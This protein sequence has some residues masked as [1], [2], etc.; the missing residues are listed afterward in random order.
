M[1]RVL[2]G[3]LRGVLLLGALLLTRGD[4]RAADD[5]AVADLSKLTQA[6]DDVVM[7]SAKRPQPLREAAASTSV[8]T[9]ADLQA[10]GWKDF[11]EAIR[12]L[13]GFYT[14]HPGDYTY[15]G[16]RGVSL[17]GD[18]NG[19]VLI[20]VDGHLQQEW[21]SH[22][23]YPEQMGLD[24]TMIDH[25]EVLR[26][27]A[28]ALYGSLGFQAIINVVTRRGSDSNWGS[29]TFQLE[30]YTGY[31]AVVNVGHRF[32]N[33]LEFGVSATARY[34]I[35]QSFTYPELT[36]NQL[37]IPSIPR[38]CTNGKTNRDTDRATNGAVYAHLNFRGLTVKA[39]YQ[40]FD[41]KIPMAPYQ[42][43]FNDPTN[44]YV[45]QR[46]Y[47]D[48]GYD[49]GT[50]QTV[51]ATVRAYGDFASYYDDLA[52]G[53]DTDHAARWI[54]KDDVKA[55]WLGA[56]TKVL[57]EREWL[58]KV[59][60]AFTGGGEFN[61]FRADQRS[62]E[63][64][65]DDVRLKRDLYFGAAYAQFEVSY[66]RKMFITLGMRGD[67]SNLVSYAWS[68]RAGLVVLPYATGTFKLLYSRGFIRPS[69]YA[70]FFDDGSAITANPR[71]GPERADNYELVFQ[72]ELRK[73]INLTAS[74]FYIRGDN[75]IESGT[76]CVP[77]TSIDSPSPAC[78][79]GQAARTQRQNLA[80]FQSLGA[81]IGINGRAWRNMRFYGNYS[82]AYLRT[83]KGGR[84]FNSPEHLFKAGVSVP[85]WREHFWIG[86]EV[87]VISSRRFTLD[88][89]E[90]SGP[91]T[92]WSAFIQWRNLPKGLAASLKVYNLIGKTFY[93]PSTAEDSYPI[94][95]VPRTG[96]SVVLRLTYE[97]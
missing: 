17:P 26:G 87:D 42:S 40:Y 88:T 19:R 20:L 6:L 44:R 52:Y 92:I 66:L 85:A 32:K 72:Q 79:M 68:P 48:I 3:L 38:T 58:R 63:G 21:W 67:F 70:R 35:G 8:I 27:P 14:T 11:I 37:C 89:A 39:S 16:V 60:F 13:A 23:A 93:E 62:G 61:W 76:A 25:I 54:F 22:S 36:N 77:A 41:K 2:R 75:L 33:G 34:S 12:S 29:G 69:W 24:A 15:F 86:T 56:E 83:N 10:Y 84:P 64:G 82:Y 7:L 96:P 49:I 55:Y 18:F 71:I 45:T 43:L 81:E 57:V 94:T 95:R 59:F 91:M 31:R 80:S 51:Q 1:S 97:R 50:P 46:G 90:E 5:P 65:A 53:P 9:A 47:L 4:A 74:T 28:S 30:D 73:N 78:P